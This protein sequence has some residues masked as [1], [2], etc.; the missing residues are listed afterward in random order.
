MWFAQ[1][2]GL[3]FNEPDFWAILNEWPASLFTYWRARYLLEP[4]DAA[5]TKALANYK[6]PSGLTRKGRFLTGA[7]ITE[8]ER[9]R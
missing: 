1:T 3:R 2:L 5:N 8:R 9:N 4:W 7:E 6:P